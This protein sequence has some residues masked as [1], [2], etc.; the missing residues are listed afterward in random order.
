MIRNSEIRNLD[1]TKEKIIYI[2]EWKQGDGA[3]IGPKNEKA[4]KVI[5]YFGQ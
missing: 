5:S 2:W 3:M 1:R 4:A